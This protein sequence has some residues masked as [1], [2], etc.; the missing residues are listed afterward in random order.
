MGCDNSFMKIMIYSKQKHRQRS[1]RQFGATITILQRQTS[2]N[3]HPQPPNKKMVALEQTTCIGP[4]SQFT[5]S[6]QQKK[7][8]KI[9]RPNRDKKKKEDTFTISDE[10]EKRTFSQHNTNQANETDPKDRTTKHSIAQEA[11]Q[12]TNSPPR[13]GVRCTDPGPNPAQQAK[14]ERE[15]PASLRRDRAHRKARGA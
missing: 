4:Q 11:L 2:T 14:T 7:N 6:R 13:S 12:R 5:P 15:R 10:G 9:Y 8:T 1:I 3:S